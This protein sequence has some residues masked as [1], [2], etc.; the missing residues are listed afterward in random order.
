M[1]KI[2]RL[3][4]LVL[5]NRYF[6]ERRSFPEENA[7]KKS[8]FSTLWQ[9]KIKKT[10]FHCIRSSNANLLIEEI[11]CLRFSSVSERSVWAE[12]VKSVCLVDLSQWVMDKMMGWLF[13]VDLWWRWY[14]T[15]PRANMPQKGLD[16]MVWWRTFFGEWPTKSFDIEKCISRGVDSQGRPHRKYST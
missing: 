6:K 13:Y 8:Y 10:P 5:P 1:A 9:F 4:K 14:R 16:I 7:I 15:Q 12:W 2:V 3:R 11:F